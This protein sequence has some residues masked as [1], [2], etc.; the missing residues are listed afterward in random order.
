MILRFS[1]C[2]FLLLTVALVN[3]VLLNVIPLLPLNEPEADFLP[4]FLDVR[5]DFLV[6]RP[7]S[8][9]AISLRSLSHNNGAEDSSSGR[10]FGF[11]LDLSVRAVAMLAPPV[12]SDFELK[13]DR[14]D[15][16]QSHARSE[17]YTI[18]IHRSSNGKQIE[19]Q[20]DSGGTYDGR[21]KSTGVNARS[22]AT[23]K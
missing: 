11:G 7:V 10:D 20:C 12:A 4:L 23:M 8:E 21:N 16:L 15:A 3:L 17:G 18:S 19:F 9:R 14:I 13:E 6:V 2:C 1:C 22:T 5:V